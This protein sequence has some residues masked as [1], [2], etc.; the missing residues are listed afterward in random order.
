LKTDDL[1]E[2]R[3]LWHT[4][5]LLDRNCGACRSLVRECL[6]DIDIDEAVM[7]RAIDAYI[8]GFNLGVLNG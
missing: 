5:G 6:D 3:Q 4:R 1:L 2:H 7:Y 8:V